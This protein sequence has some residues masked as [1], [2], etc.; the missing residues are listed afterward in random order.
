MPQKSI[1]KSARRFLVLDCLGVCDAFGSSSRP[2]VIATDRRF[3]VDFFGGHKARRNFQHRGAD[4]LGF[5]Q[6]AMA[7]K[8]L[9]LSSSDTLVCNLKCKSWWI[10][11]NFSS[12]PASLD[13]IKVPSSDWLN[14]TQSEIELA[15]T[16]ILPSSG[17]GMLCVK[18]LRPSFWVF[19][20]KA[21]I[22]EGRHFG[23][24]TQIHAPGL[25]GHINVGNFGCWLM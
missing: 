23:W 20:G 6:V 7:F 16:G 5:H 15:W 18:A 24:A 25:D 14:V 8:I 4:H 17:D 21:D 19:T 22:L 11:M 1:N 9:D 3:Q 10:L 2:S 12:L 13:S